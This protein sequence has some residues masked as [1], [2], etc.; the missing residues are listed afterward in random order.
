MLEWLEMRR[1][2]QGKVQCVI[3]IVENFAL[4][5]INSMQYGSA[6]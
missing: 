3:I 6:V 4:L 2:L 5:M 1:N